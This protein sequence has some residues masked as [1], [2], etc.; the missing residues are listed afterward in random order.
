[1]KNVSVKLL[2]DLAAGKRYSFLARQHTY[3]TQFPPVENNSIIAR[4]SNHVDTGT[5][6]I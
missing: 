1:M 6:I 5:V 3:E 4:H 2:V